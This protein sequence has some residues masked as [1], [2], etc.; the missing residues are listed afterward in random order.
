VK[1]IQTSGKRKRAIARAT[2]RP[3][4]G[5]IRINGVPIEKLT[6]ELAKMKIEELLIIVHDEKLKTV[7]ID[8]K[9]KGGGNLGQTI[10]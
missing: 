6:P 9:V 1:I 3:G 4:T 8:V 10:P 5:V 2:V 7:N